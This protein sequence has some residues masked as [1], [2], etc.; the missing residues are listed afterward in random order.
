MTNAIKE[1]GGGLGLQVTEPARTAKLVREDSEGEPTRRAET[2]VY[3]FDSVLLVIDAEEV[4]PHHRAELVASAARDTQSIY[5][6]G[7][8]RLKQGG[9]GYQI[10]LPGV[11]DAGFEV[12]DRAPVIPRSGLLIIYAKSSRRLANDLALIREEQL[13]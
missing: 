7:R 13:R 2:F 6:A 8:S 10:Q 4:A 9:H 5:V 12:G 11:E 1:S 3:S